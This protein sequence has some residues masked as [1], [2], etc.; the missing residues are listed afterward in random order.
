MILEALLNMVVGIA[1]GL[2]FCYVQTLFVLCAS[3]LLIVGAYFTSRLQWG[4]KG[5][6]W[7][8]EAKNADKYAKANALLS[9]VV[10]NYKT[11]IS[12]GSRNIEPVFD[13]FEA[14]MKEPLLKR[15]KF[16]HMSGVFFGYSQSVR[17]LYMGLIFY[18][19]TYVIKNYDFAVENVYFTMFIL[20]NATMGAG[21]QM[22]N[23][24]SINRAKDSASAVFELIDEPSTLD[25][26]DADKAPLK[27]I[28]EGEIKFENV[29]F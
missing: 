29:N 2:I 23:V 26:R 5:G 9:D 19:G 10:I 3:P 17:M 13:K 15:I 25:I 12:F 1:L 11:V 21:V 8:A 18:L 22:A 14:L 20:M 7:G 24:P 6:K 27:E 4:N 28:R 16:A